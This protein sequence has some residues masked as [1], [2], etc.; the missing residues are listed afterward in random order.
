MTNDD[1]SRYIDVSV[2]MTLCALLILVS[3][4]VLVLDMAR[5]RSK[6]SGAD[7]GTRALLWAHICYLVAAIGLEI[8]ETAAF[9]TSTTLVVFGTHCGLV[10]GYIGLRAVMEKT[11][12][13]TLWIWMA[14]G[15]A[16]AQAVLAAVTGSLALIFVTTS[17]IN[18]VA[19]LFFAL[20]IRRRARV[21][22]ARPVWL[23]VLPFTAIAIVYL[24][25]LV[26]VVA[27]VSSSLLVVA[28][29]GIGLVF[30]MA[31]VFWVFG[32]MSLR[33]H[34]L[35]RALDRFAT[36][37]ALTGLENRTALERFKERLPALERR[38]DG[39]YAACLCV[40]LDRFKE[41]NDSFGHGAGDVVLVETAQRLLRAARPGDKIFRIGGDEFVFWRECDAED[42]LDGF[43][44]NLL[45]ALQV[46]IAY[47]DIEVSVGASIGVDVTTEKTSPWDLIRR[48]DIAL[49]HSKDRGRNR[50]TAYTDTLGA[51]YDARL[52][53]LKA[54][55]DALDRDEIEAFFQ[56]QINA[57]TAAVSGCEALA[58]WCHPERGVLGP[59]EFMPLAEELGVLHLVD[60]R[61]LKL[62]VK[63]MTSWHDAGARMPQVSVNV[64]KARLL[65]SS[66][67]EDLR[68]SAA[69]C[70]GKLSIEV[71]ETVFVDDD[72]A[73]MW[74]ADCLRE[75]GVGIE[76]DDFGTGRASISAVLTLRPDRIKIDRR[77]V[78]GIETSET[79]R[80]VLNSLI[81]LCARLDAAPLIEGVENDAQVDIIRQFGAFD[82][83]G[84]AVAKPMDTVAMADWLAQRQDRTAA[85]G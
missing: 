65:E 54:F 17:V 7:P 25:R 81:E 4:V 44:E 53:D 2:V 9:A 23:L 60:R 48:A 80:D 85:S 39:R 30:P 36:R 33:N 14:L 43:I 82:I 70:P 12:L 27:G 28:S 8:G 59:G 78:T 18:G 66:L 13:A 42:D 22:D 77:F 75:I 52:A 6:K 5:R 34:H 38:M 69:A 71:L 46:P 3:A 50:S 68:N 79:K 64:S 83:Q 63:A 73:L 76:I 74:Q 55:R 21:V 29:I 56:P 57:R 51:S 10:A 49:N 37:D 31:T 26:L 67:L 1:F 40:D 19:G 45:A 61:I 15:V 11:G 16:G 84:Y 32:A 35:T 24:F 58:R 20:D 41:T 72:R 62:A 47:G